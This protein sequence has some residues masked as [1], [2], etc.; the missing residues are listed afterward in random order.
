MTQTAHLELFSTKNE[1]E[2]ASWQP[3]SRF[4]KERGM[5]CENNLTELEELAYL[6]ELDYPAK[7]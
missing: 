5:D 2:R 3:R 4:L 7:M 6:E 1:R